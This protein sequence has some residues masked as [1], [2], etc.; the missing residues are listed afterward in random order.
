V[1][2]LLFLPLAIAT[3]FWRFLALV[4]IQFFLFR[5]FDVVK[6]P[7]ARQLEALPAGWGVLLDDLAAG[8]YANIVGQI[9][10]RATP[11]AAYLSV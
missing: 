7:P 11:L 6:P 1:V 3:G 2:A 8:V 9:L 5:V 10:W 4:A